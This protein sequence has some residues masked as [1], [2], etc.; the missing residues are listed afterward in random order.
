MQ[1]PIGYQEVIET[2]K[3]SRTTE[4]L[5]S[6]RAGQAGTSVVLP[7]GRCDL[8]L[9]ASAAK[10]DEYIPIVTGPAT[11]PYSV[12]FEKGDVWYGLRMR[13]ER[14]VAVW[15]SQLLQARDHVAR[16]SDAE[17]LIPVLGETSCD[18]G[19]MDQLKRTLPKNSA[20]DS[21]KLTHAIDVI[22]S[23]GGRV[24]VENL[25]CI[26]GC[27]PRHLNRLFCGNVG[28]R[29][30]SYIQLAQFHRTLRLICSGGITLSQAAYEGGYADHAHMTRAF[31]AFG[32]FSPSA[33]PENLHLP[34]V[35][36]THV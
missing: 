16:G 10:P 19:P 22:H 8:I 13:P 21:S 18:G 29:V 15:G 1:I 3:A 32:G 11:F 9:R 5:W 12:H 36:H 2:P 27:S 28:V 14:G 35:F 33:I 6:F 17:A 24:R 31:Q 30:K 26:V 20:A 23:T 25:S 4:A 34:G 7:D